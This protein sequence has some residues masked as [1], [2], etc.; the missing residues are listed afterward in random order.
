MNHF[1][2]D[3]MTP[4]TSYHRKIDAKT[5]K[6]RCEVHRPTR[7]ELN[8]NNNNNNV[9]PPTLPVAVVTI[10]VVAIDVVAVVVTI[11]QKCLLTQRKCFYDSLVLLLLK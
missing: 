1:H 7:V 3:L 9:L 4:S 5:S 8:N 2:E 6:K 11:A 10:D